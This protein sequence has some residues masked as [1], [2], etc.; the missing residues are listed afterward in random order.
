MRKKRKT[1]RA[2]AIMRKKGKT[3]GHIHRESKKQKKREQETNSKE[4]RIVS[5][6][7][8]KKENPHK[9]RGKWTER[10]VRG[11]SPEKWTDA[12][13]KGKERKRKF[14]A[15]ESSKCLLGNFNKRAHTL[16]FSRR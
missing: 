5:G 13:E 2:R 11:D 16:V 6:E 3:G 15:K 7:T 10:I 1:E 14:N 8:T 4:C 12:E 9:M